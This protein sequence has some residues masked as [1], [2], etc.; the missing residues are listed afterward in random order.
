[1]DHHGRSVFND[2]RYRCT[3]AYFFA[4]A[5]LRLDGQDRRPSA[6]S[7]RSG[8]H[9]CKAANAVSS[10]V[11]RVFRRLPWESGISSQTRSMYSVAPCGE[12]TAAMCGCPVLDSTSHFLG[13]AAPT[14]KTRDD[15]PDGP[16]QGAQPRRGVLRVWTDRP[17]ERHRRDR[18]WASRRAH[19]APRGIGAARRHAPRRAAHRVCRER[20]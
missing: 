3:L 6:V 19:R 9:G 12:L 10:S 8:L 5:L 15:S 2:P 20:R 18:P 1:V 16:V 11:I 4:F 14:V 13:G 7:D 17:S